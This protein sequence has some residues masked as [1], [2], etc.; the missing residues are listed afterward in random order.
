[1]FLIPAG[2]PQATQHDL[3]QTLLCHL[4]CRG[5]E[6]QFE[7]VNSGLYPRETVLPED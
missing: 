5:K 3:S 6:S 4:T 1:M 2:L 7:L